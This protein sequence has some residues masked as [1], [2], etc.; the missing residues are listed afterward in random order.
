M[1]PKSSFHSE[2][3]NIL[4]DNREVAYTDK[5]VDKVID[6]LD[7]FARIIYQDLTQNTLDHE[8]CHSI[9]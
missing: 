4:N 8:K 1:D 6:L 5:E 9:H 7:A 2:A 3:K